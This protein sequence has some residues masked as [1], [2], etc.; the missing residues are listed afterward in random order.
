MSVSPGWFNRAGNICSDVDGQHNPH[1]LW[2]YPEHKGKNKLGT[3]PNFILLP[4]CGA[5]WPA[6]APSLQGW[7]RFPSPGSWSKPSPPQAAFC[8]VFDNHN[9]NSN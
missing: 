3:S 9:K 1:V 4:D 5:K 7:I 8:W 6:A 2:C